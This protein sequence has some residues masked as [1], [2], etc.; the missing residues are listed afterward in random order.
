MSRIT[1]SHADRAG[2]QTSGADA[3][4]GA[5]PVAALGMFAVL[6]AALAWVYA[7]VVAGLVKNWQNDPDY[8]VGQLVPLAVLYLLWQRR[9]LLKGARIGP[10]WWGLVPI[11]LAAVIRLAGLLFLYESVER[12]ALVLSIVGLVL[13]L[14]GF[15]V[16]WR[17]R[18]ILLLLVLMVP[19]PGRVHNM[20]SGPLQGWATASTVFVLELV[21]FTVAREG[22]VLVLNDNVH[23]AVAEACSGLRMLTAFVVVAYVFA[24]LVRR[25][26]WQRVVLF[27]SSVPVAI[28]ANML[29]LVVT[30][31]LFVYSSSKVAETFFHDFA[32]IT[33]MPI[34]IALLLGELWLLRVLILPNEKSTR[35]RKPA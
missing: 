29:R 30:A 6:L 8:S 34:A 4:A 35:Q 27:A 26:V 33:M 24:A 12:Y 23:V 22:H 28:V 2:G 11:V 31:C 5:Q 25:S 16:F 15:D 17:L 13:L 9:D 20:V 1:A 14:F 21:G 7:P 18:W 10:C 32:G 19:L 3:I